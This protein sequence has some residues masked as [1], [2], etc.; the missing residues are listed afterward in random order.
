[1][2]QDKGVVP[3]QH[4]F[5]F[6]LIA[7]G[8]QCWVSEGRKVHALVVKNGLGSSDGYV[9]TALLRFYCDCNDLRD[10]HKVFDESTQRDVVK[11]NV[12]MNG[13]VKSGLCSKGLDLFR[14]LLESDIDP[15]EFCVTT[16][17]TACAKLGTL[18][19]GKCIH[20]YIKGRRDMV[21]DAVVGT[22]LVDM[23]AKCGS[24]EMA[25]EVFEGMPER[26]VHCWAALI[27]GLAFNG[28]AKEA[29][30]C[31]D[32]MQAEDGLSPDGVALLGVL[33][34]CTHGGHIEEG[35]FLLENMEAKYGI[36]PK[37]EH[38]SC[39]VDM[40]CKAGQLYLALQIIKRMPM[41]PLASVWGALLSGC[42]THKNVEL[43]ELAV[44]ELELL[45]DGRVEDGIYVELSNIYL[46]SKKLEDASK[47]RRMIG[48]SGMKKTPGW[49][50]IEVN[51]KV[52]EFVSGDAA[53]P[54]LAQ[55]NAILGLI[56]FH[57][58]QHPIKKLI[59]EEW[60][61]NE[62]DIADKKS[63]LAVGS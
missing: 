46:A 54:H 25:T 35:M 17:I 45:G 14:D 57:L 33:A 49:S 37:H 36:A 22:A 41:K 27:C 16:A 13:Y 11:W 38:Y 4:T 2:V 31:L 58:F 62:Q 18:W 20:Q 29:I 39:V 50:A 61:T 52:N 1:M 56:S 43:A 60:Y 10:A 8:G 30:F 19:Q 32:R 47:V 55:I 34:A 59:L 15:D 5:P 42:R 23:Y 7:C 53:H 9:Q 21:F 24:I 51:G 3:D 12:L 26:N 28:Y 40:L 44:K 63:L 6:V 48:D